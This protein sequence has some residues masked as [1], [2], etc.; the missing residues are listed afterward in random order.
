[1]GNAPQKHQYEFGSFRLDAGE[2]QLR[3][4][5]KPM[6][7]TPKAFD[8]LLALI[9][10]HGHLVEKEELFQ[11]VWP[12]TMVEESNLSSN[13]ALIRKALGDGMNGERYI[14]TVPKRGYRFVAPV[15][16]VLAAG[17]EDTRRQKTAQAADVAL[18]V[19]ASSLY[20]KRVIIV[21]ALGLVIGISALV[22]F[23]WR[24]PLPPS[25]PKV[26]PFTT[27]PGR[28]SDM[29]F[30]PD[31]NQL[32]FTWDGG[33]K[34][35]TL[36]LYVKQI[37]NEAVRQLTNGPG[38][39]I[40]PSWSPD[41]REIAFI[42]WADK[43]RSLYVIPALG[44]AE[45]RINDHI[46]HF[47]ARIAWTPDGK[48]LVI[49][50]NDTADEPRSLFFVARETGEMRKITTPPDGSYGDRFPALSPDGKLIAFCRATTINQSE[51]Y[52]LPLS[53]GAAKQLTFDQAEAKWPVWTPDGRELIF[54]SNRRD[55]SGVAKTRLWRMPADGGEPHPING[56]GR[57]PDA[58]AIARQG[59]RLAWAENVNDFNIWQIE[60]EGEQKQPRRPFLSSTQWEDSPQYSPDGSK[61]VFASDRSG[62]LE[63]WVCD[64]NGGNLLQLTNSHRN[65]SPRW[66]PDGRQIVY[67]S[68][69]EGNAEIYVISAEGGTSRRLTNDAAEDIVPSWSRDGQWIYFCS[70]RSGSQQIWKMPAAGGAAV[71]VTTQG[72]FDNIEAPDGRH[73]YYLKGRLLPGIWR[74]P[75]T[76]GEETL[77]LDN[78]RAGYWRY[79]AVTAQGIYFATAEPQ[80]NARPLIEFFNFATGQI[81]TVIALERRI[82]P[83]PPGLAVSP[84]G[85][86]LLWSQLDQEGSDIMLLENFR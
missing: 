5:D 8:L 48:G 55:S 83:T 86:R 52:L 26:V 7:L 38:S 36:H 17:A 39:E 62:S 3:R 81:K 66:S 53:G 30:S 65:G 29:T 50:G 24:R 18:S 42:R 15:R 68:V 58:P 34:E 22:F 28:E 27:L 21:S 70:N 44:G 14:E 33:G 79:W 2:R 45:R 12:D 76:G 74:V 82:F 25:M 43:G 72:G 4:G 85:R 51:L 56:P 10:R 69:A 11:A 46:F 47:S 54:V 60:L 84:D 40:S 1:M 63:I 78:H 16:T 71:Q 41:G 20:R 61:I 57:I 49:Q 19:S 9:E 80:T 6:P 75:T 31:G 59:N 35:S 13:I 64:S 73:L 32:A 37:G 23:A 67:D 77:V